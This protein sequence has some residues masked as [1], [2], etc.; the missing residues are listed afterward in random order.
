MAGVEMTD[1]AAIK[2]AVDYVGELVDSVVE[3]FGV[4]V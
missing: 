2:S 1:P 4:D 3:S